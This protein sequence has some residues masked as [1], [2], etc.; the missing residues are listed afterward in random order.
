MPEVIEKFQLSSPEPRS[1]FSRVHFSCVSEHWKTPADLY[2]SLDAEFSFTLDPCPLNSVVDGFARSWVNERVYCNPP[3]GSAI[4]K[5]LAKAREAEVAVFLLP[6][7]TDTNWF[8]L[9]APICQEVRFIRGRL[10]FG[11]AAIS[12]P[13]PSCLLIFGRE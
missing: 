5:W 4:E 8:H 12:A 6:S 7:R 10:K 1:L 3:Y 9:Y 13:F 2:A 11:G